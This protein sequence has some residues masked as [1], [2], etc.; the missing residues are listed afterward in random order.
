M[1]TSQDTEM[2][3]FLG[4]CIQGH[5][6]T[7]SGS[8]VDYQETRE[9]LKSQNEPIGESEKVQ[10]RGFKGSPIELSGDGSLECHLVG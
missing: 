3:P 10:D 5:S 6:L 9:K 1:H 8:H 4:C 2:T 7:Y